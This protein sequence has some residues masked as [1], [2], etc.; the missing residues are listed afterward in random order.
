MNVYGWTINLHPLLLE[1]VIPI[2]RLKPEI[3]LFR[4]FPKFRPKSIQRK[5]GKVLPDKKKRKNFGNSHAFNL[6]PHHWIAPSS[7][8]SPASRRRCNV[9]RIPAHG[10]PLIGCCF[11]FWG[12]SKGTN[13]I[14]WDNFVSTA[15]WL[16][17]A[18]WSSLRTDTARA[19]S[20]CILRTRRLIL[21][22][23]IWPVCSKRG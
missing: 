17:N 18:S 1:A 6:A 8:T 21:W 16:R 4:H 2:V 15:T 11:P 7:P 23:R 12:F 22:F 13:I 14:W 10:F 20:S 3:R 5:A 9:Q 19:G